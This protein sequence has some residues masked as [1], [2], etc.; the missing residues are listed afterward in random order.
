MSENIEERKPVFLIPTENTL[1]ME[2]F[3]TL[4]KNSDNNIDV[5]INNAY[6]DDF[7]CK[8]KIP[9]VVLQRLV[10]ENDQNK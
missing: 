9:F 4:C 5:E 6:D 1:D 2:L 3:V 8:F 10:E 7:T